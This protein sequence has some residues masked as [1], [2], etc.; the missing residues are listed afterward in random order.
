MA[1]GIATPALAKPNHIPWTKLIKPTEHIDEKY[2][3]M[4]KTQFAIPSDKLIGK[5]N[6]QS[7]IQQLTRSLKEGIQDKIPDAQFIT[8]LD[9][10]LSG[11]IVILSIP[12]KDNKRIFDKLYHNYGIACAPTGGIRLSPTINCVLDDMGRIVNAL[13]ALN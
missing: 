7:R 3:E 6:I 13:K 2:W 10:E 5:S 11:G 4:V 9:E 12:G 8:P 1:F